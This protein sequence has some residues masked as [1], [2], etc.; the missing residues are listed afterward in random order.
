MLRGIFLVLLIGITWPLEGFAQILAH[1]ALPKVR[2]DRPIGVRNDG[3]NDWLY[4]Y[5]QAGRIYVAENDTS[6]VEP[7]LFLDNRSRVY[8]DTDDGLELGFLG[9]TFHPNYAENGYFYVFY[10]QENPF[11]SILSRFTRSEEDPRKADPES[12]LIL[13]AID[14]VNTFHHGGDLTFGTDGYLYVAIGDG[15]NG[16]VHSQDKSTFLGSII[17]IDVDKQENDKNY[18]IPPDNPFAGNTNGDLEE[19]FIYGLRNPWRFSIDH[20]TGNIWIGNVGETVWED[21]FVAS[22]GG[23][24]GWPFVAGGACWKSQCNLANYTMPVWSYEHVL[25]SELHERIDRCVTGGY[26]YRGEALPELQGTYV[27]ADCASGV[28]WGLDY[29]GVNPTTNERILETG[30]FIPGFGE[31]IHGELYLTQLYLGTVL[32]LGN[33]IEEEEKEEEEEEKEDD[34]PSEPVSISELSF[35]LAGPNPF[36]SI[37][38]LV[39]AAEE[40]IDASVKLYDVLGREVAILFN[41]FID[42]QT[43]QRFSVD[44][45]ALQS[46]TYFA[47]LETGGNVHTVQLHIAR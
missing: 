13:L 2:F 26:V 34:P 43:Y 28:V 37:T 16:K 39:I 45:S 4:V 40:G 33:E 11:Q 38:E 30:R 41:G 22:A 8:F 19:I 7:D 27:Y 44:G 20:P 29:D 46:G 31:D 15:N 10:T 6:V 9:L 3:T 25:T 21:I 5:D 36:N 35:S 42:A 47:R 23:N 12:E 32:R 18:A 1:N 24:M 17:R 14:R